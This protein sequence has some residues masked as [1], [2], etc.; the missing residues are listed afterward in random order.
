YSD[1]QRI[2]LE[3]GKVEVVLKKNKDK[4]TLNPG[5]QLLWD[6][7]NKE[8]NKKE[9]D[10]ENELSWTNNILLFKNISFGEAL[11]KINRYYGVNFKI[12]DPTVWSRH[13]TGSFEN[14]NL[15]EFISSLEYIAN[16]T[17]IEQENDQFLISPLQ[18]D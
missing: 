6:A 9:F 15:D 3:E 7:Q 17:V 12:A 1:I 10:I 11:P 13:I 2:S 5:E 14:Q 4:I 16:I 18:H 8:V